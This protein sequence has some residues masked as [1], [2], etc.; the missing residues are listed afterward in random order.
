VQIILENYFE[1][2]INFYNDKMDRNGN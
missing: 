1:V 2:K